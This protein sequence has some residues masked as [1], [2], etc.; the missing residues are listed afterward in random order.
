MASELDLHRLHMFPNQIS[1]LKRV[2]VSGYSS[3][4]RH[5]YL[6]VIISH[7]AGSFSESKEFA[8]FCSQKVISFLFEQPQLKIFVFEDSE[9]DSVRVVFLG[10]LEAC[11]LPRVSIQKR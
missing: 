11:N 6:N 10:T 1:C 4:G 7:S 9:H 3:K 2:E 5:S 8:L